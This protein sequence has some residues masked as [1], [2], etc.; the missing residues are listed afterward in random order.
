[1]VDNCEHV[2]DAAADLID[3]LCRRCPE[4]TVLATS[5]EPLGVDGEVALPVRPLDGTEALALLSEHARQVQPKFVADDASRDICQRLDGIPLALEMAAARLRS[6]QPKEIAERLEERFRLLVGAR[7]AV[8]RQQT[9][10]A[11][12]AWSHDLLDDTEKTAAGTAVRSSP[13]GF[14]LAKLPAR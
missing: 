3:R 5:R 6:M 8:P 4:L 11:T 9:L 12:V 13:G 10:R 7:R 2:L 1:M 14:D